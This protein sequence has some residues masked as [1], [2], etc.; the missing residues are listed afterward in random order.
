M[1]ECIQDGAK[2]GGVDPKESSRIR[3]VLASGRVRGSESFGE[4]QN[5]QDVL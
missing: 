3:A 5:M 4:F 2:V 1:E